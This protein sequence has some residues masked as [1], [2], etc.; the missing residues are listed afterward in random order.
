MNG[1]SQAD[2]LTKVRHA[3]GLFRKGAIAEAEA[4]VRAVLAVFPASVEAW[5]MLGII[6]RADGKAHEALSCYRHALSEDVRHAG[7]WTNLGNAWKDIGHVE[8]AI[9]CHQRAIGERPDSADIYHNLGIALMAAN[10]FE[11]AIVAYSRGLL[12]DPGLSQVRWDRALALLS[13]GRWAEGWADYN[14]RIGGLGL[15]PRSL[16]GKSWNG[17]KALGETL[18]VATEQGFGDAL[19]SWRYLRQARARVG[20]LILECRPAL[21]PLARAHG[22]ADEIVGQ[23]EV[24]PDAGLHCYQCSLPGIFTADPGSIPPAPYLSASAERI[25]RIAPALADGEGKLRVGIV[26]SGSP[27]FQSNAERSAPLDRFIESFAMPGVAL[28]SL[29]MGPQRQDLATLRGAP[30]TDLAPYLRDFTDTAAAVSVLDLVIMTDSAVAHLCG[31]LGRPVWVLLPYSAYWMWGNGKTSPWYDSVRLFRPAVR[32][33]WTGVFDATG[34][35][36]SELAV[37]LKL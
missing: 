33:D 16:P 37:K 25:A 4:T 34:A 31:A 24:I 17:Q 6:L 1:N 11:E 14:A 19:W 9:R 7:A 32:G 26:W 20:R 18:F 15:P 28:Y 35:A 10:R 5:N 23:G 21:L 27:T 3:V 2:E 36:L 12:I 13:A 22:L 30:V 29:Q 8:T